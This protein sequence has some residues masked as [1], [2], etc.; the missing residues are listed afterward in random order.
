MTMTTTT[1]T[2]T[3]TTM[4]VV[5]VGVVVVVHA[6]AKLNRLVEEQM[7]QHEFNE[8]EVARRAIA[9]QEAERR[10]MEEG[11]SSSSSSS[12]S[13]SLSTSVVGLTC[14]HR[15]TESSSASSLGGGDFFPPH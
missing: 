14:L 7:I 13:L 4:M 12:S 5:V 6:G 8:L 3:T 9:A 1:T 10:E 2:T 15:W 11:A